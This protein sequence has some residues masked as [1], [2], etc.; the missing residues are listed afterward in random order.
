MAAGI[1]NPK[2]TVERHA[3]DRSD[4]YTRHPPIYRITVSDGYSASP[5]A[6]TSTTIQHP[7]VPLEQAIEFAVET[8]F[9]KQAQL[10]IDAW[11]AGRG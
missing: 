2:V 6:Y 10:R 8:H 7:G 5:Y 4:P 1:A 11:K 3:Q 9:R